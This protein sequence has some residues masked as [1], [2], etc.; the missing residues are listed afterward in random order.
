MSTWDLQVHSHSC[1]Y[2]HK[3]ITG[4]VKRLYAYLKPYLIMSC[5]YTY[6]KLEPL[7]HT[8]L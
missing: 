1:E 7:L 2:I 6:V 8:L 4:C 5:T 3:D